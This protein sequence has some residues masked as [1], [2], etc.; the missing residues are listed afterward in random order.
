MKLT[1]ATVRALVLPEGVKDRIYFDD[2]LARFG[3]RLRAGGSARWIVQYAVGRRERRVVLGPVAALDPGKARSIAKDLLARVRLGHDPLADKHEAVARA[4]E[5]VGL[6]LQR[7]LARKRETL[8]PRSFIEVERHLLVHAKRLHGRALASVATDR[9]G[10]AVLL[11]EVA[12]GSGPTCANMVRSSLATFC[13]WLMREGLIEAN[14]VGATNKAAENGARD[15]VLADAELRAIWNALGDDR[16]SD[17]VRLL[18]LTGLRREEVGG[19]RWSEVDLEQAM[20]LLPADRCKNGRPHEVPLS[21]PALAILSALPG[22]DGLVFGRPGR[23]PFAN[24]S[25]GKR[26]LDDKLGDAVA[27]WR[28]HDL[29]RTV[30]TL[31]HDR[32]EI[33]PHIVEAVLGHYTGHRSG[34]AGTYNRAAYG[35]QRRVALNRWAELVEEIVSGKKPATVVPLRA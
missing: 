11:A 23:G 18:T 22:R 26:Q 1:A 29:R 31:M 19:L 28:L 10:I 27:P 34:A 6:H 4:S 35:G 9:R 30:S 2:E 14:P 16:Y 25:A 17:I 12:E 24:W 15:R 13:D 8:R 21:R 3:V 7:Y 20:I 32:L 33:A 5:T